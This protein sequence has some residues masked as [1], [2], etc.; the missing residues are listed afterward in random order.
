[1]TI[2]SGKFISK[3]VSKVRWQPQYDTSVLESNVL[4]TG[5]WDDETNS[6]VLWSGAGA[7]SGGEASAQGQ[8]NVNGSSQ[9][10]SLTFNADNWYV[11]QI[12][13]VTAIDDLV[14]ERDHTA[15]LTHSFSSAD[16]NFNGL[17]SVGSVSI[18]DNDFQRSIDLTKLPSEGNNKI[19]YDLDLSAN[20]QWHTQSFK[21]DVPTDSNSNY[22]YFITSESYYYKLLQGTDDLEASSGVQTAIEDK[23]IIFFGDAGSTGADGDDRIAYVNLADGGGGNDTLIASTVERNGPDFTIVRRHYS[24][25]SSDRATGILSLKRCSNRHRR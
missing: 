12:V 13:N 25:N 6:V 21:E 23:N 14:I 5:S 1:M 10:V 22:R 9:P 8:I 4:V 19:I 15:S 11:P 2:G 20:N 16:T 3:K 18:T 24:S 7:G 17:S